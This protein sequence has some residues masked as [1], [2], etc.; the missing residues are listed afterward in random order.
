MKILHTADW[1]IGKK[2]HKFDLHEDFNL[3]VK[4]LTK[5]VKEEAIDVV[6]V[7]GDIFDLANPSAEARRQ[8]Y[9]TLNA[10]RTTNCKIIITGGNHDSP[11]MLDAPSEILKELNV[12]IL[13]GM[14]AE[15]KDCL[16]PLK[17]NEGQTE[18]IVAAV[19]F[20]RDSDLRTTGDGI[21]YE[22][23]IEAIK[24]GIEKIFLNLAECCADQYPDVPVIAMGHLYTAGISVSDSER[25]IQIGNQ[26]AFEAGQFGSHFSYIALGHIHKPQRVTA[27]V[28]AFYS[29]SPL[30]LSFS[31]RKD[32]K[33]VLLLDTHKDFE[34]V[35]IPVPS[36]R[37]LIRIRGTLTDIKNKLAGLQS[38]GT[39]TNLIEVEL[40]EENF[41]TNLITQLDSLVTAFDKPQFAIIKHRATFKNRLKQTGALF[42][43]DQYLEDLKPQEVFKQLLDQQS[44]DDGTKD[45]IT[46][47]FQELLENVKQKDL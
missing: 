47:A 12:S 26:A 39:L 37:Q 5:L 21:I 6:L 41:D 28:P 2:L 40:L 43:E 35:S 1:H 42:Q 46:V 31:E 9:R 15:A 4:W 33:R 19:P 27:A 45:R 24:K 17:N 29:G 34:P 16:I 18:L 23:R 36:F 13:G 7:S 10:L 14:P 20:L 22:S 11:S 30:P 8:Y 25:D 32:D 3:F 44:Y 38:K